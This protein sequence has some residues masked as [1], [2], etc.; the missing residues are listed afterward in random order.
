VM[1][2]QEDLDTL[3]K[4]YPLLRSRS[5]FFEGKTKDRA[6]SGLES[7][8][9]ALEKVVTELRWRVEKLENDTGLDQ[10]WAVRYSQRVA[11][12][13]NVLLGIWNFWLE[14]VGLLQQRRRTIVQS[15]LK[16]NSQTSRHLNGVLSDAYQFAVWRSS[17]A[18]LC[19]LL[20]SSK[21]GWKRVLGLVLSSLSTFYLTPVHPI[22]N[23][24][25]LFSN[26][27]YASLWS[28]LPPKKKHSQTENPKTG[29]KLY[30][31]FPIF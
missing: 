5:Q 24:F 13:A 7:R 26:L 18:F 4:D 31:Y 15:F 20:L 3:L 2:G 30:D 21:F 12:L 8:F 9:Q 1:A 25:A 11:I 22:A 6:T 17:L 28:V 16:H 10:R 27:V 23:Y 14:F 29:D 19:A